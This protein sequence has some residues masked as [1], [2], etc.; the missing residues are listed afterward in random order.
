MQCL[1]ATKDPT[2]VFWNQTKKK[3]RHVTFQ[4]NK[5]MQVGH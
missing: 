3:T 1:F 4:P 5:K 2:N